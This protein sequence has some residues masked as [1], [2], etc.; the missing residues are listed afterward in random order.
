[1]FRVKREASLEVVIGAAST[2]ITSKWSAKSLITSPNFLLASISAISKARS[3]QGT[4]VKPSHFEDKYDSS[5]T[6]P[7]DTRSVNSRVGEMPT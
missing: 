1:M 7:T 6:P 2:M 5:S 3:P 4:T